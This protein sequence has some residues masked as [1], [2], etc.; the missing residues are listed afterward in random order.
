MGQIDAHALNWHIVVIG[1]QNG[2][3]IGTQFGPTPTPD[4]S[5]GR[6]GW[7]GRK[8]CRAIAPGLTLAGSARTAR[9]L[10]VG[11]FWMPMVGP[12]ARRLPT[13]SSPTP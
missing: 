11:P 9:R 13:W 3:T 5:G 8:S 10:D 4:S 2:P 6:A 1:I 7:N 12:N